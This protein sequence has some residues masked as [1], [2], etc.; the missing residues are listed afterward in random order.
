MQENADYNDKIDKVKEV[1]QKLFEK[2]YGVNKN[3]NIIINN[4]KNR[5]SLNISTWIK[6][7]FLELALSFHYFYN[8][9]TKIQPIYDLIP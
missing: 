4:N 7:Q 9:Y 6:I 2:K 3:T 5:I 1:Q 8:Y